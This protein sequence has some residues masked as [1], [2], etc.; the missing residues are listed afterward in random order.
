MTAPALTHLHVLKLP[1]MPA[2]NLYE[3]FFEQDHAVGFLS[4][5][6]KLGR[7][8][9][10]CAHADAISV[11]EFTDKRTPETVLR[12]SM[13]VTHYQTTEIAGDGGDLPPFTGGLVG[14]AAF[15]LGMRLENLPQRPFRIEGRNPWPELICLRFP[16]LLA[17]DHK[18]RRLLAL[19]RGRDGVEA[20]NRAVGMQKLLHQCLAKTQHTSPQ[21][22]MRGPL[23]LETADQVHED[24]VA[25]LVQQIHAGDLFQA[26]LAR[27]WQGQLSDGMTI[28]RVTKALGRQG[29]SPFGAV[30]RLQKRAIIS[31]SPERFIRLDADGKLE[32][33][34][35]KGTRPRGKT[36]AADAAF[37]KALIAS[38]KDRA[39]NL[40]IVDLMRHDLSKVAEVG[41]VKVEALNA[42]ETYPNVHHL[43]STVTAHLRPECDAADVL[44]NTFPPGSI[45]GAPKVQALKV[46]QALEAPRG[47]Y[48]G[49]L[50]WV[51]VG[52]AMDSS[53]L[54]R[55]A[56]C[57]QDDQNRWQV[58]LCAGGG[59]VADSEPKEERRETETKMSLLKAVFEGT[60]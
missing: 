59:I 40:M 22:I 58:R 53:V 14:L 33:R 41:S 32:T 13:A 43:V 31:N 21:P 36:T 30:F 4:D 48:C 29:A 54:I 6:G 47:P 24:K 38:E 28:G 57:E 44:L 20:Y 45:S 35:I 50:F 46:I 37:A 5:G 11:L 12:A 7:W 56:V 34:P 39:E 2:D 23:T 51:D 55:T 3:A 52:G 26:N 49:S 9:W 19:G 27:G 16:A 18:Q 25:S 10:L 60:G 42:L 1:F 17:F 15:E 8:S